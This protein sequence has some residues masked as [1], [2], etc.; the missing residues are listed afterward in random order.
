[1]KHSLLTFLA[2]VLMGITTFAASPRPDEGMWLPMF[3]DRLN[4]TDIQE[5]GLQLT[6]E[7]LYSINN[8]SL[9]DAIVGLAAGSAP[10]GYFC[11]GE[12]VSDQGLLFTNHHCGYDI[13]QNHST[14]EHDYLTDG[15]WAMNFNEE[16]SNPNLTASFLVRMEDLNPMIL[17]QLSDTMTGAQRAAKVRELTKDIKAEASEDG[18]YDVV[19]KSFFGGN[20]YYMFV[21]QTFKDVRLVGAPPSSIG[22]FGG[23]TDNWMWPRHTGDFSIFRVYS[24]PDGSPAEYAE[25]NIPFRP[26]HHLPISL[27]GYKNDDFAMIWGYPGGT[28]RYL[29][30]YGIEHAL[31]EM[32]PTIIDL[33]G[34][35]LEVMKSYMDA[36]DAMRIKYASDYAGLANTWKYMIGQSRGLKRLDVKSQKEQIEK[37]F[38]NWVNQNPQRKEKYGDVLENIQGGYKQL[39]GVVSPFYYAAIGS[40]NVDLLSMAAMA[41]Q[42]APMLDDTKKN[43]AAIEE[44][45]KSLKP[46]VED[47]FDDYDRAMDKDMMKALLKLYQKNVPADQLPS[48][49]A[50]INKDFGGD[51]DAYADAIFEKSLFADEDTFMKFL[52]KPKKKTL[53]KDLAYQASQSLQQAMMDKRAAFMSGQSAVDD[54]MRLFIDGL[55]QM[56]PDTKYYPDANSSMRFT[57]GTIKDYY[58]ADA[59][60]FDY[61]THLSG[62]MEKE[63]PSSDEFVVPEKLKQLYEAKD[64]GR[65]GEDGKLV[66]AFLSTNDITGGNSG[67]P[68]MNGDGELIGIAFDGNWEAMSGDIAFET[69]LQRTISVDIRYVLFVIDKYAGA[70][71]LID[72]LTIVR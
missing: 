11:T 70:K 12:M 68:V 18:K 16:L 17:P 49:F 22:K 46:E 1:M 38:T 69:Q 59:I 15:F 9:K 66:V 24:A 8:S 45:A 6:A 7:E 29:T 33:F 37:D 34:T 47:F 53:E 60:H 42:M 51:I 28:D 44:T 72:E 48:L 64:F 55:R 43:R 26:R 50:T 10:G 2:A 25:E 35:S 32:N 30:S 23:D 54:G 52:D 71:N 14:I 27:K 63:D 13:I 41:G 65:Y 4:W 21:Y 19:V 67:S 57:Y 56:N 3:V 58:P 40:G 36:D 61:K 31:E 20:E 62:V 39:S 5:M